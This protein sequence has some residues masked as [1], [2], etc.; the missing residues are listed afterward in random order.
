MIILLCLLDL[1]FYDWNHWLFFKGK[2]SRFRFNQETVHVR[3]TFAGSEK[4]H[5]IDLTTSAQLE[6]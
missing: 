3:S 4:V 5:I 1:L 2:G 6:I